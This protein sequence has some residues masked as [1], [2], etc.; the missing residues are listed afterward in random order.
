MVAG[1][2]SGRQDEPAV[3]AAGGTD[4]GDDGMAHAD[5]L[6]PALGI[7]L[8]QGHD[9]ARGDQLVHG[10]RQRRCR[11][12][13]DGQL[14]RDRGP[15]AADQQGVPAGHRTQLLL[16]LVARAA[17]ARAASCGQHDDGGA[18]FRHSVSVLN[19]NPCCTTVVA[20][21]C[22]ATSMPSDPALETGAFT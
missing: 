17:E 8:R 7:A 4:A 6:R 13:D 10:G 3:G 20:V 21:C 9:V 22:S 5:G 15:Q 12:D 16:E 18:S 19:A 2:T 14:R 1:C 11:H